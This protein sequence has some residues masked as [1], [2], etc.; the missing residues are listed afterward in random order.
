VF[1]R[2]ALEKWKRQVISGM[3]RDNSFYQRKWKV[4]T[5]MTS[6]DRIQREIIGR[7]EDRKLRTLTRNELQDFLDSKSSFSFSIVA[8]LRRGLRQIFK[9]AVAEGVA[10]RNRN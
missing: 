9:M 10:T 5:L 3:I 4:S 2:S 6:K 1:T 7:F 8:H